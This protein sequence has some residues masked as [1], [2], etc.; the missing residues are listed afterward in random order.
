MDGRRCRTSR[1][2]YSNRRRTSYAECPS[3]IRALEC[4]EL[5]EDRCG[6][7]EPGHGNG[8]LRGL[9]RGDHA[10]GAWRDT[11]GTA[12]LHHRI[13]VRGMERTRAR[14]AGFDGIGKRRGKYRGRKPE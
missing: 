5:A 9:G 12:W 3:K 1:Q 14:T 11:C 13:P 4:A 7:H 10:G 2:V 8:Y 6:W